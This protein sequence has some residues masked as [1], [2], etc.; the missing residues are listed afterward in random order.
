[1]AFC[2][3]GWFI[4][5]HVTGNFIKLSEH[6]RLSSSTRTDNYST[7]INKHQYSQIDCVSYRKE[8]L[9][10]HENTI[11]KIKHFLTLTKSLSSRWQKWALVAGKCQYRLTRLRHRL[12]KPPRIS[13]H[14]LP[15]A[16]Y[17]RCAVVWNVYQGPL[18]LTRFNLNPSMAM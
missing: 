12:T 13:L 5:I 7:W 17:L 16:Q 9:N 15:Y 1:M 10:K 14:S 6:N 18:L 4:D 11:Q 8:G 2:P 3:Q